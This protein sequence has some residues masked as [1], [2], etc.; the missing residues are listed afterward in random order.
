MSVTWTSQQEPSIAASS[1]AAKSKEIEILVGAGSPLQSQEAAS[2]A[3]QRQMHEVP[4]QNFWPFS[5]IFIKHILILCFILLQ[6]NSSHLSF[7][8]QYFHKF[9][10]FV[11]VFVSGKI[12]IIVWSITRFFLFF[13]FFPILEGFKQEARPWHAIL[14]THL[15]PSR[16]FLICAVCKFKSSLWIFAWNK[17]ASRIEWHGHCVS[18][19]L[20]WISGIERALSGANL[21]RVLQCCRGYTARSFPPPRSLCSAGRTLR[22]LSQSPEMWPVMALV[23][24]Q[25]YYP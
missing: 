11:P 17:V 5:W 19:A 7:W 25:I 4:Q 3:A 13:F 16:I 1:C 21:F 2:L 24:L 18:L 9:P 23:D 22:K 10:C 12:R 8:N 6:K 20:N 14:C 15:A